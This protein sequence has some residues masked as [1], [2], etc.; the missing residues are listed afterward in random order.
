MEV[1]EVN[2]SFRHCLFASHSSN[3]IGCNLLPGKHVG[4]VFQAP[5]KINNYYAL[6]TVSSR[7]SRGAPSALAY[8]ESFQSL[9]R[10]GKF[11]T[12]VVVAS[13]LF[14][15]SLPLSLSL[16]L[17]PESSSP[18]PYFLSVSLVPSPPVCFCCLGGLLYVGRGRRE[19]RDIA[20]IGVLVRVCGRWRLL[21]QGE[22]EIWGL[23]AGLWISGGFMVLFVMF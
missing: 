12:P 7:E 20:S 4:I 16:A 5:H 14:S 6:T 18:S 17:S 8:Y 23:A 3:P 15:L 11:P 13:A 22:S 10:R 21:W 9:A 19:R 1:R 2:R